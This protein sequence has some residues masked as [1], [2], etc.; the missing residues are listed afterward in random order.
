MACARLLSDAGMS[1]MLEPDA[2][3]CMSHPRWL[4]V[5][6]SKLLTVANAALAEL[7]QRKGYLQHHRISGSGCNAM[8]TSWHAAC[9]KV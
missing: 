9:G 5:L 8:R 1:L 2:V 4:Y 3:L 7:V 6:N